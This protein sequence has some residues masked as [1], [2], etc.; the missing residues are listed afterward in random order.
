MQMQIGIQLGAAVEG[1]G[2]GREDDL[3]VTVDAEVGQH[4]LGPVLM[5]V[6]EEQQTQ[7]LTELVDA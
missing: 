4:E 3:L 2:A 5:D 1:A 7:A 6:A